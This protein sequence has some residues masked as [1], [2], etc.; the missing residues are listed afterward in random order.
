MTESGSQPLAFSVRLVSLCDESNSVFGFIPGFEI[1]VDH[2]HTDVV[3]CSQLV[4]GRIFQLHSKHWILSSSI[5]FSLLLSL[6]PVV[7]AF[8]STL[9]LILLYTVIERSE[10]CA[11]V[12]NVSLCLCPHSEQGL[13]PDLLFHGYQQVVTLTLFVALPW[14]PVASRSARFASL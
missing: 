6:K 11:P 5:T 12:L 8:H 4:R 13:G 14:H 10:S 7:N 1:T 9:L 3:R 2:P